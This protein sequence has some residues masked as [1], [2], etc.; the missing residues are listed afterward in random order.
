MFHLTSAQTFDDVCPIK[1]MSENNRPLHLYFFLFI[2][3]I[4]NENCLK[5]H[6][7]F[8]DFQLFY[9]SALNKQSSF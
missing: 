9:M 6:V 2:V 1:E 7:F 8:N 4:Y 5:N 3:E